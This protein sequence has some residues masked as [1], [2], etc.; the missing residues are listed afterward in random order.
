MSHAPPRFSSAIVAALSFMPTQPFQF[1]CDRMEIGVSTPRLHALDT[2]II[3]GSFQCNGHVLVVPIAPKPTVIPITN[4]RDLTGIP[5]N[6][7]AFAVRVRT[8]RGVSVEIVVNGTTGAGPFIL[9]FC[10][11]RHFQLD[12]YTLARL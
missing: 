9:G 6:P 2:L 10:V 3:T 12:L 4:R 7:L 5:F 8:I 11:F 1:G